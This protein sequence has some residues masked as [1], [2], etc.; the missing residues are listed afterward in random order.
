MELRQIET[1]V[2]L[3][4]VLHFGQAAQHLRIAQPQVS[5][6]IKQLEDELGVLLLHR[7]KRNVGLTEAGKVFL[8]DAKTLIRDAAAARQRAREN[9]LGRRGKLDISLITS[10]MLGVLPRILAEFR[11]RHPEV[12]LRLEEMG[13]SVQPEGVSTGVSDLALCY[14]SARADPDLDRVDFDREPLL[15]VLPR[16]HPLAGR[17]EILLS[18]LA[19]EPWIMFPRANSAPIYDRVIAV[20]HKAGFSPHVV[21]EAGP[22]HTRLGLVAAGVGV[23]MVQ[24][25]W[26]QM[27]YPGVVYLPTRPTATMRLS[28]YWRRRN[29]NPVL[30]PFLEILDRQRAGTARP[31]AR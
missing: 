26:R 18:D 31:A 15:A 12:E 20:C 21:Q 2:V 13:S 8:I 14:P 22:I 6:R 30:K 9:A 4:E 29:P 27:P 7:D 1:F 17:S 11:A 3:A 5:R 25:S 28:C 23:H 24:Q 19:G 16:A 10:A